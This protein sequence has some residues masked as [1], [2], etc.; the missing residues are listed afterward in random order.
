MD[1]QT[2]IKHLASVLLAGENYLNTSSGLVTAPELE[3]ILAMYMD[4]KAAP[5]GPPKYEAIRHASYYSGRILWYIA[6]RRTDGAMEIL[7]D[8]DD[9]QEAEYFLARPPKIEEEVGRI[10]NARRMKKISE[11]R[12]YIEPQKG[13]GRQRAE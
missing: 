13:I 8:V 1:T 7:F 2:N 3:K 11:G 4:E 12:S 10:A 9:Q 6:E 5:A